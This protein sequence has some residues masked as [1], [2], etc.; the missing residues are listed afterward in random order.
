MHSIASPVPS[1]EMKLRTEQIF[2]RPSAKLGVPKHKSGVPTA[3]ITA[4]TRITLAA[5]AG[6]AGLALLA[7]QASAYSDAVTSAC[8]GDYLAYCGAYDENSAQGRQCMRGI[9]A[10]LSQGCVNALVASGEVSKGEVARRSAKQ[11]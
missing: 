9:G 4:S 11:R 6:A 3:M 5:A 1:G 7:T 10:K 2:L 8:T